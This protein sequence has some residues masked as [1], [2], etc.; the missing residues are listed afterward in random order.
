MLARKCR[1]R[2]VERNGTDSWPEL[3]QI[4]IRRLHV[5]ERITAQH[6]LDRLCVGIGIE[7]QVR[8]RL[9][10][11]SGGPAASWQSFGAK[12]DPGSCD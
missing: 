4:L 6:R 10:R 11:S 3:R 12:G 5:A 8:L 9:N 1:H 2:R 7:Q